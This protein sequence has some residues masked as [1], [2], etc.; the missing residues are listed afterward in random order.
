MA[1]AF[2]S[3]FRSRRRHR[4][5]VLLEGEVPSPLNP[6][7]GCQFHPRC[8]IAGSICGIDEPDMAAEFGETH[9]FACHAADWARAHKDPAGTIPD[10]SLWL[11]SSLM[12]DSTE[13]SGNHHV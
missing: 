10:P 1:I 6:P 7:A 2:R 5:Q 12:T 9:Y 8:P 11:T 4:T 3:R 13:E